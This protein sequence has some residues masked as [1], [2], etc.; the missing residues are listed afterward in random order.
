MRLD[1]KSKGD[2]LREELSGVSG[3]GRLEQRVNVINEDFL[4]GD[5]RD[6]VDKDL[7]ANLREELLLGRNFEELRDLRGNESDRERDT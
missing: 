7:I 1:C 2:G 4:L 6:Q 5:L 3:E